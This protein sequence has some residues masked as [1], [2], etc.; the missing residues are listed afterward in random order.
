[1]RDKPSFDEILRRFKAQEEALLRGEF[2][3]YHVGS[4]KSS[5]GTSYSA[6][7]IGMDITDALRGDDCPAPN[8]DEWE[9]EMLR[10][11]AGEATE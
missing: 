1:M 5:A 4:Y 9:M 11:L 8:A 2:P 6:I 7:P 10:R 3:A